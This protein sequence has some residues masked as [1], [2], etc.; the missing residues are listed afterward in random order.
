MEPTDTPTNAET[1]NV[2]T[3]PSVQDLASACKEVSEA[4]PAQEI[5]TKIEPDE[6][7]KESIEK[8]MTAIRQEEK[9]RLARSLTNQP[10][11]EDQGRRIELIRQAAQILAFAII[12][13]S[14]PLGRETKTSLGQIETA[15]MWAVKGIILNG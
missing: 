6:L 5:N 14:S 15:V 9:E 3:F 2:T 13:N 4:L 8:I 12:D 1:S 10:C 7:S 11:S